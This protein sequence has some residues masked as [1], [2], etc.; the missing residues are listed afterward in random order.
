MSDEQMNRVKAD[1]PGL[2]EE[3]LEKLRWGGSGA[4]PR[5]QD[6]C[7]SFSNPQRMR[8]LWRTY[9]E[10]SLFCEAPAKTCE[11]REEGRGAARTFIVDTWFEVKDPHFR[12]ADAAASQGDSDTQLYNIEFIG[13]RNIG[14]GG[15]GHLGLSKNK[16]IADKVLSIRRVSEDRG[17]EEQ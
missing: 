7:F 6:N 8:G 5:D 12:L 13:R 11:P 2:S 1:Y 14:P 10:G 15:F 3:C 17:A 9:F 4:L 16:V